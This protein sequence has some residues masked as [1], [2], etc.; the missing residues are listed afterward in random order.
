MSKLYSANA[1]KSSGINILDGEI[2]ES[3]ELKVYDHL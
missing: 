1:T 3:S 2:K